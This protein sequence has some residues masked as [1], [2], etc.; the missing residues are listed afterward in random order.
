MIEDRAAP[1]VNEVGRVLHA[2]EGLRIDDLRV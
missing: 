2:G 1:H